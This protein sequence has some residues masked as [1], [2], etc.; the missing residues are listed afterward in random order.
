M[1]R[2]PNYEPQ[3]VEMITD[4]ETG[5]VHISVDNVD[6]TGPLDVR[7]ERKRIYH[8]SWDK[9]EAEAAAG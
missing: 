2:D 9:T 1:K 4:P 6:V 3:K 5:A 7:A 8:A